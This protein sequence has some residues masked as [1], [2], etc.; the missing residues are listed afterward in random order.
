[1]FCQRHCNPAGFP[2]L[3]NEKNEWVFNSSAAE[4]ANVWFGKFLPVVREMSL[5]HYNFYLDEMIL[6]Y[7]EQKE[8]ALGQ[9]GRRPRL[10]PV[11]ELQLPR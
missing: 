7:N 2:E 4:Q 6:I 8:K 5:D 9:K 3:Y 11:E 1:M 10:I